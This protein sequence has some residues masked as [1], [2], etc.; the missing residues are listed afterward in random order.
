[1][2]RVIQVGVGGFGA[3]WRGV[4]G[5]S[6]AVEYAAIV[7]INEWALEEAGDALGVEQSRRFTDYRQAIREVDADFVLIVVPPAGDRR[8]RQP[9]HPGR[10]FRGARFHSLGSGQA[11]RGDVDAHCGGISAAFAGGGSR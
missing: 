10:R 6:G 11:P 9:Q 4:N 8:P 3:R 5:E 1:V 7:D 2:K